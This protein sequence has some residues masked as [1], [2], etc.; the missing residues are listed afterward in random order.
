M[1]IKYGANDCDVNQFVSDFLSQRE[2]RPNRAPE[3]MHSP[4]RDNRYR[5]S[6]SVI[7]SLGIYFQSIESIAIAKENRKTIVDK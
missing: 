3:W 7:T 4:N 2:E 5:H 6:R 1:A